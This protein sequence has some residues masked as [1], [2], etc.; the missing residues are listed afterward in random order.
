[1]S[2]DS[3][4]HCHL[5]GTV[6]WR[7]AIQCPVCQYVRWVRAFAYIAPDGEREK[8][9][10][11]DLVPITV[12]PGDDVVLEVVCP[13]TAEN[14]LPTIKR[15][16]KPVKAVGYLWWNHITGEEVD[17]AEFTA[18]WRSPA[19]PPREDEQAAAAPVIL[20]GPDDPVIVWGE[21]KDRLPRAE[22][23]VLKALVEARAKGKRLHTDPL[24]TATKD[25]QGNVVEDPVGALERLR[26]RDSDWM[27]VIDMAGNP[28]RGYGL[29][30]RPPTPT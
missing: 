2:D 15:D 19:A 20:D 6:I 7:Y 5:C 24:R 17:D 21:K 22:Y 13:P 16:A 8:T 1:M 11:R 25:E 26:S 28:G 29:K 12:S 23:R 4:V 27:N 18:L 10:A 30:D 14:P 9:P 3:T